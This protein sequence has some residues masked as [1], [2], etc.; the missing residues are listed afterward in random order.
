VRRILDGKMGEEERQLLTSL[1]EGET[2]VG[3]AFDADI[4][5]EWVERWDLLDHPEALGEV[6]GGADFDAVAVKHGLMQ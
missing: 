6:L 1:V 4:L 5:Y 3:Y 2:P